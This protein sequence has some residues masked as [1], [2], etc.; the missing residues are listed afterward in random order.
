[1]R[2]TVH[3]DTETFDGYPIQFRYNN[4]LTINVFTGLRDGPLGE[5]EDAVEIDIMTLSE[6]GIDKAREACSEW[7]ANYGKN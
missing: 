7:I 5:L 3:F 4:S 6:E 2:T 1:M